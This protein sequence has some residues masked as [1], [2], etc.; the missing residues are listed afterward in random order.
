MGLLLYVYGEAIYGLSQ[1]GRLGYGEMH[2]SRIQIAD[3]YDIKVVI[4]G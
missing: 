3:Y 4:S 2:I 1:F